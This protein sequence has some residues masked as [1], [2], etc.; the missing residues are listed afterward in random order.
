MSLFVYL[1]RS[2]FFFFVMFESIERVILNIEEGKNFEEVYYV[3]IIFF[4]EF[5][6]KVM[7]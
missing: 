2:I 3:F 6:I 1:R 5:L 7:F 4:G